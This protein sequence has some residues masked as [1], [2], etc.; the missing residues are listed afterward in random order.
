[1]LPTFAEI[2]N[3]ASEG[4]QEL[5][6]HDEASYGIWT[7]NINTHNEENLDVS[8]DHAMDFGMMNDD[9]QVGKLQDA[10]GGTL[11]RLSQHVRL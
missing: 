9:A 2:R 6:I 5:E 1:M 10:V 4:E 7:T 11:Y 8:F 3:V